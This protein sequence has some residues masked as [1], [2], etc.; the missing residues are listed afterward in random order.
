MK[1]RHTWPARSPD[2]SP[3]EHIWDHL[4]R[5]VGHSTSLNKPEVKLQQKWNEMSQDIIQ[6]LYTSMPDCITS[7]IRARRGSTGHISMDESFS[8]IPKLFEISAYV[9]RF[10]LFCSDGRRRI[11]RVPRESMNPS[12]RT[13]TMLG[14][15]GNILIKR[16]FCWHG[17]D[18]LVFL[19]GKQTAMRYLD[20]LADQAHPEMLHFYLNDNEYFMDG[21]LTIHRARIVQH[22]CAEH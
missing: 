22:W 14:S 19:E 21:N 7:C 16:I 17:S 4:G 11:W 20:I 3:I 15:V 18:V 5:R 12:C 8:V 13:R 10:S 6:N 1:A 9:P 2:L